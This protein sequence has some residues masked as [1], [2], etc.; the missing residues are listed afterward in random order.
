MIRCLD[1]RNE[2]TAGRHKQDRIL[3]NRN[4]G[5]ADVAGKHDALHDLRELR[6]RGMLDKDRLIGFV[7]S[8][9]GFES[10]VRLGK[11]V[12]RVLGE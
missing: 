10:V 11:L 5:W 4:N 3:W 7:V 9:K 2:T 1:S 12:D 8:R 6:A